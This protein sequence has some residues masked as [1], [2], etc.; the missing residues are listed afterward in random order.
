MR[1]KPLAKMVAG[2]L[3]SMLILAACGP[4]APS[5]PAAAEHVEEAGNNDH[6]ADEAEQNDHHADEAEQNDHMAGMEHMHVAAPHEFED[7]SNPF[8]G[9]A[10]AVTAGQTIF[11]TNCVTCH[12]PE[13][14]G[15][16]PA[17]AGLEPKPASLADR[18]MMSD[19]SDGY[20]FW[21]VSEGG[22]MTPFNSAMPA[23][24]ASLSDEEM[25]Q[26]ITY[27]RSLSQ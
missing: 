20:L 13:G 25:W 10:A 16:G 6:H 21:R 18:T 3:I 24:K 2:I 5:A 12:G 1:T 11:E 9:D 7:L 8:S 4:S 17:A 19:L 15:D 22:A 27:V 14:R 26:V 23:W